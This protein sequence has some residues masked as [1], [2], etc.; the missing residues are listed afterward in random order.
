MR[1][2]VNKIQCFCFNE[3]TLQPGQTVEMPVTFYIDPAMAKDRDM[4]NISNIALSYV[5]FPV[6][7]TSAVDA[8]ALGTKGS[9]G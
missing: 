4:A 8:R 1:T 6:A 3:Q 9:G 2:T 5:F 7:Q